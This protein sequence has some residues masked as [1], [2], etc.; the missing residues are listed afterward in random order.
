MQMPE[1]IISSYATAVQSSVF[2][3]SM[4]AWIKT[5]VQTLQMEL[6]RPRPLPH[7]ASLAAAN[8]RARSWWFLP[9]LV[10]KARP[11]LRQPTVPLVH[12]FPTVQLR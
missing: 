5:T 3:V 10:A 1:P 2:D 8:I 4:R 11:L 9:G 6:A 12:V 7:R